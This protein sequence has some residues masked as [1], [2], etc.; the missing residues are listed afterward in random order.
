MDIRIQAVNFDIYQ[1]LSDH[2][3]KKAER[4][5][6]RYPTISSFD[7]NLTLLKPETAANKEVVVKVKVPGADTFVGTKIADTFEE[8]YDKALEAVE[9]PLERHKG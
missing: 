4:L 9:R 1:R 7:V 8:A 2:I 3:N 6:R 5:L